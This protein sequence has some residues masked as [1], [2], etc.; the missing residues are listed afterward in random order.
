MWGPVGSEME[1]IPHTQTN[2]HL[3]Q[4]CTENSSQSGSSASLIMPVWGV[5]AQN[6]LTQGCSERQTCRH[7]HTRDQNEK[8]SCYIIIVVKASVWVCGSVLHSPRL[9]FNISKRKM[10]GWVCLLVSICLQMSEK[11]CKW[12][13]WKSSV[14][15]SVVVKIHKMK[16]FLL[17]VTFHFPLFQLEYSIL[18]L[19]NSHVAPV[20]LCHWL[21]GVCPGLLLIRSLH[22]LLLSFLWS[23]FHKST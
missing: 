7:T 9:C 17:C 21:L 11:S 8:L 12:S 2:K 16:M 3:D 5:C 20:S 4:V 23:V 22:P 14:C 6:R 15:L 13:Q 1:N 10:F 19:C 18:F